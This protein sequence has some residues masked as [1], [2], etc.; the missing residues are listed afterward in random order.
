MNVF[1]PVLM[2]ALAA[3]QPASSSAP[4]LTLAEAVDRA[5]AASASVQQAQALQRAAD[6]EVRVT[7]AARLPQ[8]DLQAGYSRLSD[9][10]ELFLP[11]PDGTLRP[12]FPNIPNNYRSRAGVSAPLYTG[13]RL[14]ALTQ[15]AEAERAGAGHD[16]RATAADVALETAGAYWSLV[17]ARQ[18]E[19][20]LGEALQAYE[21]HLKDAQNREQLG[22]SAR[23]EVL[24]VQVERDRAQ[25]AALRAR[26]DAQVA[27][28]NLAR[29]LGLEDGSGLEPAEPLEG[30]PGAPTDVA[31]LVARALG[32]RPERTAAMA[33]IGAAEAL[34]RAERGARLPQVSASAGLDYA[35]PNR[36]ILP[37][38]ARFQES[39]DVNVNVSWNVFDAGRASAATARAQARLEAA[40]SRLVDVDR[41]IRL[42]V[43]QRALELDTA[44]GAADVAERALEAARENQRVAGERYRAGV[45]SSAELLDAEV[46]LLRA[47]LDRTEAYAQTRLAEAALQ[48]AVGVA[49]ATP[50]GR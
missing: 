26:N 12:I 43:T 31:A 25:L 50:P 20:V 15:S 7:R 17:T 39:W 4:A 21:A 27:Q 16:V 11:Q 9:V 14:E 35:N 24:S 34:V 18:S 36:R 49:A 48:R 42:Q 44:R 10:P 29:L 22:L 46:A 37:P 33:R 45:L 41:R 13:G 1:A 23:N 2:A 30:R 47:S 32:E 6:A 38:E 40:R 5:L 28:A 3:Q 8:V 19:R